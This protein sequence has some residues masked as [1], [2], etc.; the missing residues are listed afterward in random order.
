FCP[1]KITLGINVLDVDLAF[2]C[3]LIFRQQILN[4]R[5]NRR[6][7]RKENRDTHLALERFKKTFRVI[8]ER[9]FLVAGKIPTRV[10][11]EGDRVHH[12]SQKQNQHDLR[13]NVKTDSNPANFFSRTS[14]ALVC[15]VS[16]RLKP[17][18]AGLKRLVRK[19]QHHDGHA[20]VEN[21][22]AC[23]Y[24]AA[25]ERSHVF[26]RREIAQQIARFRAHIEQNELN[27]AQEKQKRNCAEGN[28]CRDDLVSG[29][30][31]CETTDGEIKHSEQ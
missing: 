12:R 25:R 20:H 8:R 9:I 19:R 1:G 2:T 28:D 11:F 14:R 24:H 6:A 16:H 31:G 22:W 21:N 5:G 7:G 30:N 4:V 18:F 23:I 17:P 29:Q 15:C 26:D 10:V 13:E 27:Q 3:I